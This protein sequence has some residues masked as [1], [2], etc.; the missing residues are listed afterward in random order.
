[1]SIGAWA[2]FKK[3]WVHQTSMQLATLSVLVGS[4]TVLSIAMLFQQNIDQAL[5]RWGKDVPVSVYLSENASEKDAA[6]IEKFVRESNVFRDIRYLSKADAVEQF[7]AKVGE[8]A[9]G[10]L[11]DFEFSNPLPASFEMFIDGGIGTAGAYEELVEL[12]AKIKKIPN[13]DDVIYGQGWVENY[14]AV[15]RVFSIISGVFV[16]SLLSGALF[17][18]GNSIRNSIVQRKEEIEI[19]ELFGATKR[20]IVWPY[21]FEGIL[22]GL[23][24]AGISLFITYALYLWQ[25]DLVTHELTFW[26][27]AARIQFLSATR[28]FAIIALGGLLG[29]A[30]AYLWARKVASGWAAA[31]VSRA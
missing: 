12:A 26:S 29:G 17:V 10:L 27:F 15:L 20:M 31:E 1:M 2:S 22:M 21:V 14:A 7:K 28:H 16:F 4:F 11:T 5:T 9:P 6:K 3:N 23:G 8:Y 24:A 13:V 19:L 25:V 18:I 30:G